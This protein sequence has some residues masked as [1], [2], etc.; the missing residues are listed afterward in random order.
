A[1]VAFAADRDGDTLELSPE[2]LL[3][4]R[5]A[6]EHLDDFRHERIAVAREALREVAGVE[7]AQTL[8][9]LPQLVIA[10]GA[11]PAVAYRSW[12]YFAVCERRSAAGAFAAAVSA[13]S[14]TFTRIVGVGGTVFLDPGSIA[15]AHSQ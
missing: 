9:Q 4:R 8:E 10:V 13:T 11:L 15:E 6:V 12:H 3:S 2:I 14:V 5:D 7:R 1:H